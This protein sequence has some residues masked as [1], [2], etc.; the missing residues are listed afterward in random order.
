M[1]MNMIMQVFILNC[2]CFLIALNNIA[3]TQSNILLCG[4]IECNP[5][6]RKPKYPCG[7]C[8]KACTSYKGAKASI[9]CESCN[10]WFHSECVGLSDSALDNL[11][12]SDLP[13]ECCRCGLPNFSSGLFNSTELDGSSTEDT[14]NSQHSTS[15]TSSSHLGSPLAKSSPSFK[16]KSHQSFQNLRFLR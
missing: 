16:T 2:A 10:A 14:S 12:R 8:N 11:G 4:D 15:S 5:G 3:L 6:P 13:W 7:E 1:N 9:L